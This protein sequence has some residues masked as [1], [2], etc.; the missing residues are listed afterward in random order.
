MLSLTRKTDY[1]LV[2]LAS[3]G[4]RRIAAEPA[5]S[6]R[7]VAEEF[8]LPLPLLMNILKDLAHAG[9]VTSTRGAQGGYALSA[10]P[11]KISLLAVVTAIEGPVRLAM[12]SDE[13]E[14]GAEK[15]GIACRCPVRRPIQRLNHRLRDFLEEVT[16]ADLMDERVRVTLGGARAELA[17]AAAS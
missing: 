14:E 2:A 17:D 13:A 3:L 10:D 6:A 4:A 11:A 15:C 5:V 8:D 12:C 7:R 9:L 1:A 16:L